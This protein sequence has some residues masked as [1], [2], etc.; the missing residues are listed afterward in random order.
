[1]SEE[2]NNVDEETDNTTKNKSSTFDKTDGTNKDE[3]SISKWYCNA[4]EM[5]TLG[6]DPMRYE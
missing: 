2:K 5:T 3:C 6:S 4:N 1:M